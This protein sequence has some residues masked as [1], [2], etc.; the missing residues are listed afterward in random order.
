MSEEVQCLFKVEN[1]TNKGNFEI[2]VQLIIGYLSHDWGGR[3]VVVSC[4]GGNYIFED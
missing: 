2:D 4:Q 1:V 3:L